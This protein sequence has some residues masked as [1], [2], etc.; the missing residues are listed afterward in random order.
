[1]KRTFDSVY[2]D[3]IEAGLEKLQSLDAQRELSGL[4]SALKHFRRDL[5][6]QE[7]TA[8]VLAITQRYIA[9]LNLFCAGGF[10]LV[11]PDDLSFEPTL[12]FPEN[13]RE[14]VWKL[15]ESGI[16]HGQFAR[17]LRENGSLFIHDNSSDSAE[18][19][20]LHP[21]KLSNQVL[22]MFCGILQTSATH[23]VAFS[24]LSLLL[25]ECTDALAT[26]RR[27]RQLTSQIDLLDGLLPFCAWCKKVRNDRGYWEQ[28]ERYI[29][30]NSRTSLT[31]GICPD[32]R[33]NFL[34]GISE[35][36]AHPHRHEPDPVHG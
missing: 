35:T 33:K 28:I 27:T 19:S 11:N 4:F 10:W 17:A 31:H 9:G 8:A 18:L 30:Q 34:A 36:K 1:M 5:Q 7:N 24:L 3:L 12:I 32:C 13:A 15:A 21:M 23:E 26:L 2:P 6:I 25:G 29:A 14:S 20:L 16:R 22:G